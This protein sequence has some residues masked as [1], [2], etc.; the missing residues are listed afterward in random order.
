MFLIFFK[1]TTTPNYTASFANLQAWR[2]TCCLRWGHTARCCRTLYSAMWVCMVKCENE[3]GNENNDCQTFPDDCQTA[4]PQE[5][6][7]TCILRSLWSAQYCRWNT[8]SSKVLPVLRVSHKTI[9][10]LFCSGEK[11]VQRSCKTQKRCTVTEQEETENSR[12]GTLVSANEPYLSEFKGQSESHSESCDSPPPI[13]TLI[14]GRSRRVVFNSI[15]LNE[16]SLFLQCVL[17][18]S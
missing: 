5:H 2:G 18:M 11:V 4:R 10:C 14:N 7:L 8:E 16:M 17:C 1:K 9:L 3:L 15:F 6:C 13:F 12:P